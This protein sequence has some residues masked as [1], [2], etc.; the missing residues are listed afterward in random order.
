[1]LYGRSA[2]KTRID[3]MLTEA[4][5]GHS[6]ALVF[7]GEPGIG[8]STLL[9]YAREQAS[10]SEVPVL[11]GVGVEAE[12]ELPY[13]ALH[14][15]L[16]PALGD[17]DAVPAPQAD[18]LRG[19]FGLAGSRA[20]DRFL[21]G[22]A[23]LTL[24]AEHAG[25]GP[26][27]CLIDDAQ[28]LDHSSL[29][30][31]CFAARRLGA[32]G[33][34]MLFAARAD[35]TALPAFGLPEMEVG[36][37]GREESL[38][39][40]DEFV[41]GLAP[42]LQDRIVA[43]TAGNPLALRELPAALTPEQRA[44]WL[45][46]EA[47]PAGDNPVPSR[48]QETYQARVRAL[49]DTTRYLL[50][51]L[52]TEDTGELTVVLDAARRLGAG[53]PDLERAE[54][55]NLV[56]VVGARLMFRHPLIRSA[57]HHAASAA[58]RL[59]VH[60]ALAETF[61]AA[62]AADRAAWHR[63]AAST[64][65]DEAVA[66]ALERSAEHAR[67][68]GGYAA[69]AAAYQRAAELTPDPAQRVRR[70]AS[71]A[72]AAADAGRPDRAAKLADLAEPDAAAPR[73]LA[74]LVQVR[75]AIAHEQDRP[76]LAVELAWAASAIAEDDPGLAAVMLLDAVT[77]AWAS[78]N[79]ADV[80]AVARL[81]AVPS[82]DPF[83]ARTS[84]AIV[85]LTTG[86]LKHGVPYLR[87]LLAEF[88]HN[89]GRSI[90]QRS[91]IQWWFHWLADPDAGYEEAA[92]LEREC[93]AQGAIGLLP[94]ALMYLARAELIRGRLR[95]AR[96]AADEGLRIA[97]DTDQP[98]FAGHLSGLLACVAAIVGDGELTRPLAGEILDEG[99]TERGVECLYALNILDLG[100]GRHESVLERLDRL[101]VGP[102]REVAMGHFASLPDYVE[103]AARAGAPELAAEASATYGE[104]AEAT[105]RP[106][107]MAVA[108]RCRAILADGDD[109]RELYE[110]A[111]EL[112]ARDGQPFERART[113]LLFGSWLRR[114]LFRNDARPHLRVAHEI[115]DQLGAAEWLRRTAAELRAAGEASETPE[116]GPD[117]L[118]RLTPQELQVA[119]L[120]ADGLSNRDIAA[121]L[122][123]SPRTVGYHLYKAYPKLG[124]TSRHELARM[125]LG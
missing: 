90:W 63:A 113:E 119:R 31:M 82:P 23:T 20:A 47:S 86:G 105:E 88:A 100:S 76:H 103:A 71:A 106:W 4:T 124:V 120:A 80:A 58:Q 29:S 68:R 98:H 24:L 39:F 114:R 5:D 40:L 12:I 2:E 115:F 67:S 53:I 92:A 49:P 1:M 122:F 116:R 37:L 104:W 77:A 84:A 91:S 102:A 16:R 111:A 17:L 69:V 117:V 48:V 64:E 13:G 109:A 93:R 107:A 56:D 45:A 22:L 32:E 8:K 99:L 94:R 125:D 66:S 75:S 51:V 83:L 25:G 15:I 19:A 18:A 3:R 81:A 6:S 87:E 27:L 95:A 85:H 110:A 10:R 70:L 41:P 30:A 43:E 35:D 33:I 26:L 9:E 72:R 65:P 101:G 123:L 14:L 108:L 55:D 79:H 21:V 89:P 34:V 96:S 121:Q 62:S 52:A 73:V 36:G 11:S 42:Q 112:H 7:R 60:R 54:A 59:A 44:G 97:Q 28:W 46:P 78:A 50:L 57:T 74:D 38:A 61:E 118:D